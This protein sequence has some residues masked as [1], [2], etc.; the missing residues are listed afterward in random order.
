MLYSQV[1]LKIHLDKFVQPNTDLS[2]LKLAEETGLS[3]PA[4]HEI[5]TG[6]TAFARTDSIDKVIAGLRHLTG[7]E[8]TVSDLLEYIP[9]PP[10]KTKK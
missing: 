10:K 8:I 1:V 4:L 6:K 2:L 7:R 9:D 5:K 3:Y